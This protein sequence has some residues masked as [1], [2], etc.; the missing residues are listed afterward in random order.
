MPSGKMGKTLFVII[1][2]LFPVLAAGREVAIPDSSVVYNPLADEFSLDPD[3]E[4]EYSRYFLP[5]TD[6][7]LPVSQRLSAGFRTVGLTYSGYESSFHPVAVDGTPVADAV[8]GAVFWNFVTGLGVLG[9]GS[10]TDR[11]LESTVRGPGIPRNLTIHPTDDPPRHRLS[12][13]R[14]D[15]GYSD[16]VRYSGGVKWGAS[17]LRL[18]ADRRWG[19]DGSV[20][21]VFTDRTT[22]AAGWSRAQDGHR[23]SVAYTGTFGESGLRAAAT[24]EAFELAGRYYNP[25]WGYQNGKIR[26]SRVRV[27][28]QHFGM[29][30]YAGEWTD[31]LSAAANLMA[32]RSEETYSRLAWYD[33]PTP[34]PDYYRSMPS[35]FGN[36][37]IAEAVR[38][39]WIEANPSITQIDW[40][41]M[42]EANRTQWASD[43]LGYRSY[44]VL[45]DEVVRRMNVA[46][47]FRISYRW[48]EYSSLTGG[49][50]YRREYSDRFARMKDLLGGYYWLDIDQYLLDDEYYGEKLAN[51]VRNPGR[52]IYTD[53]IFGYHYKTYG[54]K[55][56]GYLYGERAFDR[57]R[58]SA[59]AQAT[60]LSFRRRGLYEKEMYPGELSYGPSENHRF[61]GYGL[62]A[63]AVYFP[64]LR[65]RLE[66]SVYHENRPPVWRNVFVSPEYKNET[67]SDPAGIKITSV[68]LDYRLDLTSA[69]IEARAYRT[70]FGGITEIRNFYDDVSYEY[71]VMM[72]S[73]L[74][75][76]HTGVEVSVEV[77]PSPVWTIHGFLSLNRYAYAGDPSVTLQRDSDSRAVLRDSRAQLDGLRASGG[78]QSAGAVQV[79][80][81]F[82]F[83]WFVTLGVNY[84]GNN[85][86]RV[87]PA[88][89]M[90]RVLDL[91]ASPEIRNSLTGQEK[92]EECVTLNATVS[93]NFR[94][95]RGHSLGLWASAD[96]LTNRK[97]IR[98]SGYEQMRVTRTSSASGRMTAPFPSKYYYAYGRTYYVQVSYSF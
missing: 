81:R 20:R 3:D 84:T 6:S 61:T 54:E 85:Y 58:I 28:S 19:R 37:E 26:N 79:R 51:D 32:V 8:D 57:W 2:L 31:N 30:S 29:F 89:R 49:V 24:R 97:N 73:G 75:R 21:G 56:R 17:T 52:P 70:R 86:V 15:R 40:N 14:T 93:K 13:S 59:Q 82:P 42:Y 67:V 45:R 1:S 47:D 41:R 98:M 92:L 76:I 64:G 34:A 88:Q 27:T 12:Y 36:G 71:L 46:A 65:H 22:Y 80:H 43:Q 53:G 83:R 72:M 90:N 96:N 78:P 44:Y 91:A 68:A 94:L 4:Q 38:E 95:P 39:E 16:R 25:N 10:P 55:V 60:S 18:G 77:T 5:S 9:Y 33:S 74:N 11:M 48:N 87:N 63:S 69:T 66:A 7:R 35:F 50:E 23:F 62:Q